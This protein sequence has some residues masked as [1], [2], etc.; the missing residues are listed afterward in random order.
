M[1]KILLIA[2]VA[3]AALSSCKKEKTCTCTYGEGDSQYVVKT[4]MKGTNKYLKEEC[5][6][7]VELISIDGEAESNTMPCSLD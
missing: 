5:E 6:T 3:V 2:A 7:N 4:E 1:K